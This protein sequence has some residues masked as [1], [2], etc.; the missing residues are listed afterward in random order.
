MSSFFFSPIFKGIS[1]YSIVH[2]LRSNFIFQSGS[3]TETTALEFFGGPIYDGTYTP[4]SSSLR[5]D[6]PTLS[7]DVALNLPNS[8]IGM[9]LLFTGLAGAGVAGVSGGALAFLFDG[10]E[11]RKRLAMLRHSPHMPAIQNR[12]THALRSS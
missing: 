9:I 7:E 11:G 3:G 2:L 1:G 6:M 8:I 12:L 10:A 4:P 5:Q